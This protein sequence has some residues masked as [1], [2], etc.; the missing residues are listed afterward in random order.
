M[1]KRLV[2]LFCCILLVPTIAASEG[3]TNYGDFW[4]GGQV[5]GLFTTETDPAVTAGAIGGYNFCMPYRPAW[6][7]YFGVAVD[8]QWNQFK[9]QHMDKGDQFALAL[10]A[11]LQYPL[12]GDE[13][14]NRGRIVPF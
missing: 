13:R 1:I 10:L 9:P 14:F 12:M 5:G 3:N 7:R 6:Q 4:V 8:F 11:R 2:L